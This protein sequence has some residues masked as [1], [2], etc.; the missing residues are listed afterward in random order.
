MGMR[1]APGGADQP[2]ETVLTRFQPTSSAENDPK[3]V[4]EAIIQ[5]EVADAPLRN[6]NASPPRPQNGPLAGLRSLTDAILDQPTTEQW[7]TLKQA[8][9]DLD[10]NK[11]A[12]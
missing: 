6:V 8:I 7:Q 2:A 5:G 4:P 3:T 11:N 9:L 10:R 1:A 12:N